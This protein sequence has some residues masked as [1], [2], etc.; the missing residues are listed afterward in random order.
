[1][2]RGVSGI[3]HQRKRRKRINYWGHHYFE[4]EAVRALEPSPT[5]YGLC[6]NEIEGLSLEVS[7]WSTA[8]TR[9]VWIGTVVIATGA[10]GAAAYVWDFQKIIPLVVGLGWFTVPLLA[11]LL[12]SYYGEHTSAAKLSAFKHASAQWSQTAQPF[13]AH[14]R[15][16][17]PW[18]RMSGLDFERAVTRIFKV[19]GI[20]ARTTKASGDG[21]VDIEVF[22]DGLLYMVIQCK[23]YRSACG[24]SVVRELYGV[25]QHCHAPCA[26]LIG[27]GG[28]TDG[29]K[30]FVADN[31][32]PIC[33]VDS[34]LLIAFRKGEADYLFGKSIGKPPI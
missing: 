22:A 2:Q 21:G 24:P 19:R 12:R 14:Q 18:I 10:I 4:G 29:A 23:R 1:M 6:A 16:I 13:L 34:K 26:M 9:F 5:D 25:M 31:N 33:L 27:L 11:A 32:K 17:Q 15:S 3:M 8:R 30:A 7:K 28:F 20:D